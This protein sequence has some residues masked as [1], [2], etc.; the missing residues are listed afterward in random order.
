[1]EL[2]E[3]LRRVHRENREA[4]MTSTTAG[5]S[6]RQHAV[7]VDIGST[8][9]KACL[10]GLGDGRLIATAAHPTT[11]EDICEGLR[12]VL[13]RLD[14]AHGDALIIAC[15]SA[16][17]GLRVAVAGLEEDLTVRAGRYAA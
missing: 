17:G 7:A 15:S 12:T 6:A 2:S 3:A 10:V 1:M 14:N 16:G 9:T 8:Y 4:G 11:A 13:E 5:F